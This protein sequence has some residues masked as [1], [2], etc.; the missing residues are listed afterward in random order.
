M[1]N[2]I[3]GKSGELQ[4]ELLIYDLDGNEATWNTISDA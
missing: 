1:L 4:S 3:K 2:L